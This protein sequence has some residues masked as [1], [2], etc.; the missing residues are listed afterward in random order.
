MSLRLSIVLS[1]M[2]SI[3]S[4]EMFLMPADLISEMTLAISFLSALLPSFLL[5]L[6]FAD[7][8]PS[9]IL[10]T[11]ASFKASKNSFFKP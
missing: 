9:E 10:F 8:K 4:S 3:T 7:C 6:S 5:S 2:P 11:P 1:G